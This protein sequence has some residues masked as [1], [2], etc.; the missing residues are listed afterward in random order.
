ML[1]GCFLF[2]GFGSQQQPDVILIVTII[3]FVFGAV[4][5]NRLNLKFKWSGLNAECTKA[6]TF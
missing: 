5:V 4:K 2:E 6:L 1:F 3:G